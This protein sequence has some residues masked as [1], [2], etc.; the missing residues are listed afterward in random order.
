[1]VQF[2]LALGGVPAFRCLEVDLPPANITLF[3][4]S[5]LPCIVTGY[6]LAEYLYCAPQAG[7]T[8]I[9][10][11]TLNRRAGRKVIS[12][13]PTLVI[14]NAHAHVGSV[15]SLKELIKILGVKSSGRGEG[16]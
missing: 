14:D 9:N 8:I 3:V 15:M 12:A 16:A 13:V 5:G 1:M 2:V 4:V 6:T 11:E 10:A 7:V